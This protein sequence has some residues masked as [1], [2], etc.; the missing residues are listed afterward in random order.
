MALGIADA[1]RAAGKTGDVE[2][3]GIDGI[4]EA[5]D[6]VRAG[7]MT[8]TVSQYP[9]VMG[10]MAIEACVVATRGAKVPPRVDA[11]IEL[12]TKANAARAIAAFPHPLGR[13]SDPFKRLLRGRR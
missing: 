1:L 8:A 13:Y 5:L 4:P 3:I 10:Q 6:A 11:P 7:V 2:V 9:Y 12:V